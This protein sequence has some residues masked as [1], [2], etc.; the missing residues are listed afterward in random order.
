MGA[1]SSVVSLIVLLTIPIVLVPQWLFF[2][3]QVS[4][5]RQL[6]GYRLNGV[7]EAWKPDYPGSN[8]NE[9]DPAE[10]GSDLKKEIYQYARASMDRKFMM[11]PVLALSSAFRLAWFSLASG[12]VLITAACD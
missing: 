12:L 10:E 2:V 3:P 1:L 11:N 5:A 4:A 9:T 7:L 6:A 8:N